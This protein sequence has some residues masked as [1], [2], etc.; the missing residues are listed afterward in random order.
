MLEIDGNAI[1][2]IFRFDPAADVGQRLETYNVPYEHW[3][4]VKV[5]DTIRYIYETMSPDLS[6]R[7]PCRQ[8]VCGGCAM[9]VNKKPVLACAVFS[10]KEMVIEPSSDRQV[11]KDLIVAHEDEKGE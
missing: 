8:Q 1:V 9:L 7:E 4:G 5:I 2:T 3:H 11:L 6:F 10:E